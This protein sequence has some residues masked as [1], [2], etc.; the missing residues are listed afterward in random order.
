M[1]VGFLKKRARVRKN[2]NTESDEEKSLSENVYQEIKRKVINERI[3]VFRERERKSLG[4]FD[5]YEAVNSLKNRIRLITGEWPEFFVES[6]PAAE[7]PSESEILQTEKWRYFKSETGLET[8]YGLKK[9]MSFLSSGKV[10]R[11]S[12]S[13][14][15]NSQ[16][17]CP[18]LDS[19][20]PESSLK[21]Y[22]MRP[23]IEAVTD[24]GIIMEPYSDIAKNM[25]TCFARI[26]G[27]PVGI[28]AN[29]PLYHS[30]CLDTEASEKASKFI[31]FCDRF[32]L[33]LITIADAQCFLSGSDRN[34][35]EAVR[36]GSRFF[37]SYSSATVPKILLI[38]RKAKDK[39]YLSI[40]SKHIKADAVLFWPS[41]EIPSEIRH[42][43][44]SE[45]TRKE[46]L[47]AKKTGP[48]I[49]A[50][51]NP[52]ELFFSDRKTAATSISKTRGTSIKPSETRREIISALS[53]CVEN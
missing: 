35:D 33:P 24:E 45:K 42:R 49:T 46:S 48:E 22:D 27:T 12:E 6:R 50:K 8:I 44:S 47:P 20:I 31:R 34:W 1:S 17:L 32:N 26:D 39:G 21:S 15:S 29:Q 14:D 25:I 36:S 28:I 43:V 3:N 2:R 11:A 10:H 4:L 9:L 53:R 19:I 38:T 40:T 23:V 16:R 37:W 30:G 51:S 18:E 7:I 5:E 41:R 52:L 13:P